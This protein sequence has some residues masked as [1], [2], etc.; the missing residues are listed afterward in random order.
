MVENLEKRIHFNQNHQGHF[1]GKIQR[2]GQEEVQ[3]VENRLSDHLDDILVEFDKGYW[4]IDDFL[5]RICVQEL[6][7]DRRSPSTFRKGLEETIRIVIRDEY[8][9]KEG[10]RK[11]LHKR[12]SVKNEVAMWRD[13][14]L[15]SYLRFKLEKEK[16]DEKHLIRSLK[17]KIR[18]QINES[19]LRDLEFQGTP[20]IASWTDFHRQLVVPLWPNF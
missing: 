18:I 16:N 3:W 7:I 19:V 5:E 12:K 20:M 14:L 13:H 1:S 9:A 2:L 8:L 10:Y 4:T 6:P 17:I 11:N 15:Y